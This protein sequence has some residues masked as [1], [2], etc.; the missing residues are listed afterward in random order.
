VLQGGEGGEAKEV[1]AQQTGGPVRVATLL[2]T[3]EE[4]AVY[5]VPSGA[6]FIR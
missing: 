6:Y 4:G 5:T 2:K 1:L 3:P